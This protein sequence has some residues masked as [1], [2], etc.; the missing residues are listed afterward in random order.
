M[1]VDYNEFIAQTTNRQTALNILRAREREPMHFT[2]FGDVVGQIKGAISPGVGIALNG[3]TASRT[4]TDTLVTNAG[5]TGATTGTALTDTLTRVAT[6]GATNITPSI[7]VQVTTGTDFKVAANTTDEFYKGILNPI[8]AATVVHY[9]RQGFPADLLSYLLIGRLEFSALVTRPDGKQELIPLKTLNNTPDEPAASAEFTA[10]IRCR[11]LDYEMK[12]SDGSSI[13]ITNLASL[14]PMSP[15]VLKRL[16]AKTNAD[17]NVIYELVTPPQNEFTLLLSEPVE[18]ECVSTRTMLAQV[19][20]SKAAARNLGQASPENAATSA[21]IQALA[22][23]LRGTAEMRPGEGLAGAERD[24]LGGSGEVN[25]S[26]KDYFT[27]QLPRGHRGDLV[28]DLTLRS[29][30]GV[31]YYLGE[32]VRYPQ[33][34]P[35]LAGP[36]PCGYCL[37]IIRIEPASRIPRSMR[38][39]EV[40]YR[41]TRYAVPLAGNTLN[42][43]AGRSSQ[44][45]GLVQQL[46][47]LNRSAKDL[48][49]TPLVRVLN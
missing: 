15:D 1:A 48:P 12:R 32:Y 20:E 34:S 49:T 33:F 10:A 30:E 47:N 45:I 4:N 29:V 28:I 37:P 26:S 2:S 8:P 6:V 24:N 14:A 44:T 43:E 11:R 9:L 41:G 7:G 22:E 21:N 27:R 39:V 42:A 16:R 19:F 36:P 13:P 38:F 25:F 46:L 35:K 31:L 17:G 23:P 18:T 3:D 5:A 40:T